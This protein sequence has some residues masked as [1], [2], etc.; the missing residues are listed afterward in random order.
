MDGTQSGKSLDPEVAAL[1]QHWE[2]LRGDAP[3]PSPD[4]L[5]PTELKRYLS[6][7]FLLEGTTVETMRV[8]LGGTAYRELYGREIRGLGL[9]DLLPSDRP[10][11][12]RDYRVCLETAAPVTHEGRM[13]WREVGVPVTYKRI[14]LPFGTDGTVERILGFAVFFDTAG[15]RMFR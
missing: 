13:T 2:T 7:V 12:L 3:L 4:A 15:R 1:L 14:L 11:V 5:D 10:D 8:R 9:A 6:R